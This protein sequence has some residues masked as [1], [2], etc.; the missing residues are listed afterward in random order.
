ML[1][2]PVYPLQWPEGRKRTA[3]PRGDRPFKTAMT[4][5]ITNVRGSLRRFGTDT[6]LAIPEAAIVFSSNF[7]GRGLEGMTS[8]P[9]DTGVAVWFEWD[10]ALR[11]IAVDRYNDLAQNIQAIHHLVEADRTKMR[12]GG[13]EIVRTAYKGFIALPAPLSRNWCE[14]LGFA[15]DAHVTRTEIEAAYRNLAKRAHPDA[16]GGS[17]A[18]WDE[19]ERA[20]TEALSSFG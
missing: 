10:G 18:K 16:N 4:T 20:K 1:D 12:Y 17:R 2:I 13:L 8:H 9:K 15:P 5:A 11:C 3:T 6:G 14:V 7:G 19:L